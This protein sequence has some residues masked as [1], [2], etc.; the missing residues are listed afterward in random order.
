M[1]KILGFLAFAV[2]KKL[3][4]ILAVL[5]FTYDQIIANQLLFDR[6]DQEILNI[7]TIDVGGWLGRIYS[8]L[9]QK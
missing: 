4:W 7:I 1:I 6:K 8:V 3:V 9:R 2:Q 5:G